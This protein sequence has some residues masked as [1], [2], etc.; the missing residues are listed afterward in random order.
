MNNLIFLGAKSCGKSKIMDSLC[1]LLIEKGC[2]LFCFNAQDVIPMEAIAQ[3][4][5]RYDSILVEASELTDVNI[6]DMAD[7]SIVLVGDIERGGVFAVLYGMYVL[8]KGRHISGFLINKFRGDD[9]ILKPGLKFLE[10]KTGVPFLGLI[11][12]VSA[13]DNFIDILRMSVELDLISKILGVDI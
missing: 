11:P 13:E 1:I 5:G 7:T 8:L 10:E 3:S 9:Q 12:Y 4:R 2:R 6:A